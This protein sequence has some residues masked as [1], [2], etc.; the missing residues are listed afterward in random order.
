MPT[1]YNSRTIPTTTF[2]SRTQFVTDTVAP[3]IT[4]LWNDLNTWTET[5]K[6]W[7]DWGDWS[8]T[9]WTGRTLI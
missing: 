3:I 9:A 1:S 2:T 5:W 8:W 4:W 7:N 6:Y